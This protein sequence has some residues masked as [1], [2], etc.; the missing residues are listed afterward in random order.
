MVALKDLLVKPFDS[1]NH[2]KARLRSSNFGREGSEFDGKKRKKKEKRHND[3]HF[4][5]GGGGGEKVTVK[6]LGMCEEDE[7]TTFNRKLAKELIDKWSRPIFNKSTRFEDRR[8]VDDDR[9]PTHEEAPA[10]RP[11]SMRWLEAKPM[12]FVVRPRSK[13]DPDE[14]RARAKQVVQEQRRLEM[15]K[16]LQQL[17][18]PKKKQLQGT[19]LGAGVPVNDDTPQS[20]YPNHKLLYL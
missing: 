16:K 8:N 12:D 9:V 10:N 18:A 15:N 1:N 14:I 13:I 3:E 2:A 7:E 11:S 19:K 6:K 20:T 5:G 4:G 17:K